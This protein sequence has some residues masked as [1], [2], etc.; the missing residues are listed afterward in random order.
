M[1]ILLQAGLRL[2]SSPLER[3]KLTMV[4]KSQKISWMKRYVNTAF[5]ALWRGYKLRACLCLSTWTDKI[6]TLH[7]VG[8][9]QLWDCSESDS[10]QRR[11]FRAEGRLKETQ[12]P[13]QCDPRRASF[14]KP[15][16]ALTFYSRGPAAAENGMEG[17]GGS[18]TKSDEVPTKDT[19]EEG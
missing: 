12:L 18:G 11:I 5:C 1:V 10:S 2:V 4:S 8:F 6:H 13:A 16:C 15:Y 9:W 17:R 7:L 19:R 3:R 14:T